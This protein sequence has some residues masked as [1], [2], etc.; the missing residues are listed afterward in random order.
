MGGP[1]A[2]RGGEAAM[3]YRYGVVF[4]L[5]L[6]VVPSSLRAQSNCSVTNFDQ[7]VANAD[8]SACQ[9]TLKIITYPMSWVFNAYCYQTQQGLTSKYNPQTINLP[10]TGACATSDSTDCAATYT[11]NK[12]TPTSWT[13]TTYNQLNFQAMKASSRSGCCLSAPR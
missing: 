3:K 2:A 4:L 7:A 11:W 13:S 12:V 6:A 10:A 9:S 8:R 1:S 5:V